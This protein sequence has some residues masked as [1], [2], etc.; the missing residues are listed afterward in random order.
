MSENNTER[1]FQVMLDFE[2]YCWECTE[3]S[4]QKAKELIAYVDPFWAHHLICYAVANHRLFHWKLLADL[5]SSFP[6]YQV[7]EFTNQF[8][9]Y[10]Y[11][12]GIL[13]KDEVN[14][15]ISSCETLLSVE[16]YEEKVEPETLEYYIKNDDLQSLTFYLS[17]HPDL[18]LVLAQV[19]MYETNYS[20]TNFAAYCG[21]L[22]VLKFLIVHNCVVDEVTI[23]NA[24]SGGN[25]ELIEFLVSKH[26]SFDNMLFYAIANHHNSIARW[27][28]ENYHC[29]NTIFL[30]DCIRL[31]NTEIFLFY[32]QE[33]NKNVNEKNYYTMT[34]LMI[35][36]VQNNIALCRF[37]LS[38]GASIY[39]TDDL[40]QMAIDFAPTNDMRDLL[41]QDNLV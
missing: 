33:K 24:V 4:I 12:K 38:I 30:P 15:S 40:G 25:E 29:E 19:V 6:H 17:N 2:N 5:F 28:I 7:K 14:S 3:E 21:S 22:N 10:L 39:C 35:G 23:Q 26:Y 13:S 18:N 16:Q 31:F 34:H 32:M 9:C 1:D 41:T 36:V 11:K 27:L 20:L 37:I 8:V